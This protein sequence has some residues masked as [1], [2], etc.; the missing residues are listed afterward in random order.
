MISGYIA[1]GTLQFYIRISRLLYLLC[2]SSTPFQLSGIS[3]GYLVI[4]G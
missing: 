1:L 3:F 2:V 4:T